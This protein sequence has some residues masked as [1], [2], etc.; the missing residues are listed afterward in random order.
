MCRAP[1]EGH[2]A[3]RHT[4]TAYEEEPGLLKKRLILMGEEVRAMLRQSLSA[5]I[6]H[7]RELARATIVLDHSVNR[8]EVEIDDLCLKILAVRQPVA[9]DL[10]FIATARISP[11]WSSSWSMARTSDTRAPRV[12]TGSDEVGGRAPW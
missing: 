8:L 12:V 9:S 10:R 3:P 4:V 1:I 5:L 6:Q 11:R 2:E 7:D